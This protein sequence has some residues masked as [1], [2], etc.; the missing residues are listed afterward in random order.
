MLSLESSNLWTTIANLAGR[1]RVRRGAVAYVSD[2]R[3]VRF[4]AN[5][6]L[7]TDASDQSVALGQTSAEVI[8]RAVEAGAAV[9]SSPGMHAKLLILDDVVV[10]GSQNLSGS[11]SKGRL[12]EAGIVTDHPSVRT[13]ANDLMRQL[14]CS[15][16]PI[17]NEEVK[18]LLRIPVV[19]AVQRVEGNKLPLIEALRL[20]SDILEDFVF[21]IWTDSPSC[22]P[23]SEVR[24]Q[25]KKRGLELPAR[26]RW[27]RFEDTGN[28][29]SSSYNKFFR[30]QERKAIALEVEG[31]DHKGAI[32]RFVDIGREMLIYMDHFLHKGRVNGIYLKNSRLPFRLNGADAKELRKLLNDGL[33]AKPQLAR[34]LWRKEGGVLQ[35]KDLRALLSAAEAAS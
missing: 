18:R 2:D 27:D 25:A 15:A 24:R 3:V 17:D 4:R 5:D 34:S 35:P 26:D 23:D 14:Q 28:G 21:C 1:A 22:L 32:K 20:N 6:L 19:K 33:A 10:V 30:K 7:I 12:F 29:M 11:S 16:S 13:A 9:Y 31:D 8:K